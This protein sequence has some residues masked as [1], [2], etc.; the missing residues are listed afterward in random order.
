MK[1]IVCQKLE[2]TQPASLCERDQNFALIQDLKARAKS[3]SKEEVLE[4]LLQ[5]F[6][7][8]GGW[9]S[10]PTLQRLLKLYMLGMDPAEAHKTAI[11]QEYDSKLAKAQDAEWVMKGIKPI[12]TPTSK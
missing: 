10:P 9:I 5:H 3:P 6:K 12:K 11:A 7:S 4:P 8:R 2:C 1:C